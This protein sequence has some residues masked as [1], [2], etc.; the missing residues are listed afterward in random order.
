MICFA[1]PQMPSSNLSR[2]SDYFALPQAVLPIAQQEI[3]R[4]D[5]SMAYLGTL[6]PFQTRIGSIHHRVDSGFFR[7]SV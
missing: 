6:P 7:Y 3:L 2:Y 1:L 5:T 4:Y